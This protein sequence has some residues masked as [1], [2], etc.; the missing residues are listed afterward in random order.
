MKVTVQRLDKTSAAGKCVV[1]FLVE[2]QTSTLS[3]EKQITLVDGKTNE[4]YTEDA[5]A[6]CGDQIDEWK[7]EIDGWAKEIDPATG[8]FL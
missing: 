4:S 7:E 6:L 1:L 5:Y 8:K 3:I 2:Y